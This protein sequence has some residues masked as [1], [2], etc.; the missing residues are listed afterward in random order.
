MSIIKLIHGDCLVEMKS[1]PDRSIDL[2]LC[3]SPY[4]T[5]CCQWDVILPIEDLWK[6]YC[7]IISDNGI[8]GLFGIEPFA[9]TLRVN[10]ATA[11]MYRY[12]WLWVK[13]RAVNFA[14]APYMPLRNIENI[15]I[16]SKA[17]I[18]ANSKNRMRYYPQGVISCHKIKHGTGGSALRPNRKRQANYI[19]TRTNYPDQLLFFDKEEEHYHPT[20]K[21]IALLQYLINSYTSVGDTVLDNT[22][23]A[24]STGV[25]CVRA[26][27]NFIGIELNENFYNIAQQRIAEAQQD[28]TLF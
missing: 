24:G 28:L 5:T 19:Q 15:M 8:I 12:D 11:A 20:Q 1:I 23:G 2:I 3:D 26:K 16:F 10:K 4:G 22:M 17:T 18:A 9:S 14:Q 21:P 13:N 7:R 27:R 25:A 6:E